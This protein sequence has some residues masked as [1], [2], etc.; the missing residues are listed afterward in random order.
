VHTTVTYNV[1][2]L[3]YFTQS[4]IPAGWLI[5]VVW[6]NLE[7]DLDVTTILVTAA[8]ATIFLMLFIYTFLKQLKTP[9]VE[10]TATEIK[11]HNVWRNPESVAWNMIVGLNKHPL[12]GYKLQT[13]E[14]GI[15]IPTGMLTKNDSLQLLD[16]VRRHV[17]KRTGIK[18]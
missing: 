4:I 1:R 2:K 3:H 10:T 13:I 8:L 15:W 5:T 18:T 6:L 14:G 9:L 7:K 12:L 11:I 16:E 17:E